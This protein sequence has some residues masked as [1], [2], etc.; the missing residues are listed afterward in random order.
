LWVNGLDQT[1]DDFPQ[2]L[3]LHFSAT[4]PNSVHGHSFILRENSISRRPKLAS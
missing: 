1:G 2:H 3:V 4:F